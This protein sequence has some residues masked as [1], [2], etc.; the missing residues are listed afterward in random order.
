MAQPSQRYWPLPQ[1]VL[2]RLRAFYREPG[3]VFWVYGF[4]LLMIVALG[5]AFRAAPVEKVTVD[6]QAAPGAEKVRDAL[7]R[8]SDGK[9]LTFAVQINDEETARR[10]LR[11][12]RTDLVVIIAGET[13]I[14]TVST[15]AAP[16]AGGAIGRA[17][18][19]RVPP[20]G[21]TPC[22]HWRI[23]NARAGKPLHRLSGAGPAGMSLMS[24]GLWASPSRSST[25][26]SA[27][28]SSASLP[29]DARS[30]FLLG[31]M[32][33]RLVFM[34]RKSGRPRL[35]RLFFGFVVT[36]SWN[37]AG[38]ILVGVSPSL[39]WACDGQP[40]RRSNRF[41]PHEPDNAADVAAV[42]DL[43]SPDRFRW[44][45]A[46]DQ[47]PAADALIEGLRASCSRAPRSPPRAQ[48]RHPH[49]VGW[50]PSRWGSSCS[51]ELDFT[52]L[53]GPS[54]RRRP[55]GLHTT[56]ASSRIG[57]GERNVV[58]YSSD[59]RMDAP[60]SARME[61]RLARSGRGGPQVRQSEQRNHRLDDHDRD[62]CCPRQVGRF[63]P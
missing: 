19:L 25:C 20:A 10:R 56:V 47:G 37:G 45:S 60:T 32:I 16:K 23:R 33:S 61:K 28:C 5:I 46:A 7:L 52:G 48:H 8:Q 11:T 3:A 9:T 39:V 13:V 50:S 49:S 1:I 43:F 2:A 6:V 27:S 35:R 21:R 4:P 44:R 62:T 34:I 54:G 29:H 55:E 58:V 41:R 14:S 59:R 57:E 42:G 51:D 30:D 63:Q 53:G 26:G 22:R 15:E 38:V 36:G 18:P 40:R 31:I 17:R 24:G 12:G